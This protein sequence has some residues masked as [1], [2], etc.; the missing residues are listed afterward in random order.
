MIAVTP[1]VV[2]VTGHTTNDILR[3]SKYYEIYDIVYILKLTANRKANVM[4]SHM[5]PYRSGPLPSWVL[6]PKTCSLKWSGALAYVI[7]PC[8]LAQTSTVSTSKK[9]W[10]VCM[11][12]QDPHLSP[13]SSLRPSSDILIACPGGGVGIDTGVTVGVASDRATST[14][15][16]SAPSGCWS[17]FWGWRDCWREGCWR[18]GW[19]TWS[20]CNCVIWSL[21]EGSIIWIGSFTGERK[22]FTGSALSYWCDIL[23]QRKRWSKEL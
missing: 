17:C 19:S 3:Q 10:Y 5:G 15:V 11:S 4:Q 7:L 16:S 20:K 23:S 2:I 12:K 6:T 14:F 13:C 21:E 1:S 8:I 22:G 9:R 18:E